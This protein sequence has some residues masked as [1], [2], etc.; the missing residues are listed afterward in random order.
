MYVTNI[1]ITFTFYSSF[2]V[3]VLDVI[4]ILGLELHW[5][6]SDRIDDYNYH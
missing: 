3:V 1:H 4:L 2:H 6:F 5:S